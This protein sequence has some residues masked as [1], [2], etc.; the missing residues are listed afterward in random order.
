MC[1]SKWTA[2]GLQQREGKGISTGTAVTQTNVLPSADRM[3][4]LPKK[5]CSSEWTVA[6]R[7][8]VA[9]RNNKQTAIAG[10]VNCRK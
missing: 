2:S 3:A 1:S 4:N 7:E 10:R 6:E 9:V 5:V 8:H